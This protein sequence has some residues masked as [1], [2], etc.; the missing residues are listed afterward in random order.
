MQAGLRVLKY[1]M[2]N[3]QLVDIDVLLSENNKIQDL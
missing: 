2:Y 1:M 3:S